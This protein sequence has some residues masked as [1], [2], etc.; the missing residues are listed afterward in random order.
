MFKEEF[1]DLFII[2]Q[3]AQEKT[4]EFLLKE[5]QNDYESLNVFVLFHEATNRLYFRENEKRFWYI[6][7]LTG[8][9]IPLL[10][11][12]WAEI[13]KCYENGNIKKLCN[14]YDKK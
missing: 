14:L 7:L 6:D 1:N 3:N 12:C 10:G 9:G 5:I 13:G 8:E 11:V 4:K 2:N